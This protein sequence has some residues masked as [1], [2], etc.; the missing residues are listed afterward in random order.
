MALSAL[1]GRCRFAV[2]LY[3]FLATAA[4]SVLLAAQAQLACSR[5]VVM[6]MPDGMPGM[7]MPASSGAISLCPIVLV[8]GLAAAF[9]TAYAVATLTFGPHRRAT[10]RA[11]VRSYAHLPLHVIAGSVLALGSASVGLMMAV[12][13]TTPAG[14]YGWLLLAG[15]VL[16]VAFAAAL[17]GLGIMRAILA[18]G[19]R[20]ALVLAAE[21][22]VLRRRAL[23]PSFAQRRPAAPA[24]HRVPLLAARRGLRAPPLSVR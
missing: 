24:G 19:E 18:L 2:P 10:R 9:L 17:A 8:L 15:I 13:G 4:L 20:I 22:H 1:V 14:F 11:L 5:H 7:E 16:A 21:L 3:A 6:T 12:D 23:V